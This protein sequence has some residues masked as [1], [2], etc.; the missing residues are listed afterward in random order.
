MIKK[1]IEL[2][3]DFIYPKRCLLCD[4]LYDTDY[5][6]ILCDDCRTQKIHYNRIVE[7]K[8]N[9]HYVDECHGLFLYEEPVSRAIVALK[10]NNRPDKGKGFGSL[11]AEY[12]KR[13]IPEYKQA[14]ITDVPLGKKRKRERRYNQS[15][16]LAKQMAKELGTD[17]LKNTVIRIRETKAQSTLGSRRRIENIKDCFYVVDPAKVKGRIVIIADDVVTT[18]STLNELAKELKKAGAKKVIGIAAATSD[19]P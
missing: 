15:S 8:I 17:F 16:I 14:V 2:L 18:G 11:M 7:R 4:E 19:V 10:F 1:G 6:G 9:L 13:N 12:V 3:L 5:T